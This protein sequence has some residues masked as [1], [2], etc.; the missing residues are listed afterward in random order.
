M[1]KN[2]ALCKL[3]EALPSISN[4][5]KADAISLREGID[6]AR[7]AGASLKE[8]KRFVEALQKADPALVTETDEAILKGVEQVV[9][10]SA[11]KPAA[12]PPDSFLTEQQ[13]QAVLEASRSGELAWDPASVL[14]CPDDLL[15]AWGKPQRFYSLMRHPRIDPTPVMWNAVRKRWPLLEGVPDDEL[16]KNLVE[17]RKEFAD[18]RFL[19]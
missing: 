6:E 3:N 1:D 13:F 7:E 9:V 4:L 15:T 8:L 11:P 12:P 10:A 16:F 18:A 17:C 5:G 19:E 14:A 2:K